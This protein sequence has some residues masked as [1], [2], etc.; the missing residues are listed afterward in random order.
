MASPP[1]RPSASLLL[2]DCPPAALIAD[3][4]QQTASE[5]G[6]ERVTVAAWGACYYVKFYGLKAYNERLAAGA[7][8]K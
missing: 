8:G 4:A 1:P 2:D 5:V 6:V 3:P 7:G